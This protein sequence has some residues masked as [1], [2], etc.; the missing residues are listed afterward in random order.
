MKKFKEKKVVIYMDIIN[1]I[2]TIFLCLLG[3]CMCYFNINYLILFLAY[4]PVS[5]LFIII[6]NLISDKNK[7]T[8]K[9]LTYIT[10]NL[11]KSLMLDDY[12]TLLYEFEDL[13]IV[14]NKFYLSFPTTLRSVHLEIIN[15]IKVLSK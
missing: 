3:L 11:D 15:S 2:I 7:Y 14:D 8:R 9:F 13:C 1:S 12:L 4:L 10:S 5:L 6:S